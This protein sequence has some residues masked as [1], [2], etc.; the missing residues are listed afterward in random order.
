M[1]LTA[2]EEAQL[3]SSIEM[4]EV[5]AQTDPKDHESLEI[6]KEAYSKLGREKDVINTSKRI[7]QAYVQQGQLS[8]AIMEYESILQRFP[9]D[10]EVQAALAEIESK[11]INF[12]APLTVAET[13]FAAKEPEKPAKTK[14]GGKAVRAEVDDGRQAMHK[15][16]V[17]GKMLS[18]GDFDL[19]WP[20]PNL[21]EP[22][23]QTVEPFIQ[24]LVN[25]GLLPLETSLK[26]I[27]DKS[28]LG[29]LALDKYDLDV[30]L[31]RRYPRDVCLRW[32]VLPFDSMS[33]SVLAAT[34]NPFNKQATRE[35]EEAGATRV[36][37]YICPPPD[38][39][40]AVKK[41]FRH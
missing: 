36:I 34:A 1:S 4:F 3:M 23:E 26:L 12:S 25:K 30:E 2:N 37:W 10:A 22:P 8:S 32:C 9:N 16:F 21:N 5:I 7:A 33:K 15:I 24:A 35:L 40:K 41:V 6:L 20:A 28:R 17:E 11:A 14:A 18:A 13:E 27:C 38:L 29:F 39:L 19:N 31:A